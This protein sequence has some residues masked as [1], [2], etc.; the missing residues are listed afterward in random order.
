MS[1][2][3]L[4][5]RASVESTLGRAMNRLSAARGTSRYTGSRIE[6]RV[7]VFRE[8]RVGRCRKVRSVAACVSRCGVAVKGPGDTDRP[9]STFLHVE[10]VFWMREPLSA[11]V[12]C[13][14]VADRCSGAVSERG[15]GTANATDQ[16]D[17]AKSA[18]RSARCCARDGDPRTY[19][20]P[21]VP[22]GSCR[23]RK[24]LRMVVLT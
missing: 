6:G 9:R 14:R 24:R 4:P 1:T 7:I 5:T 17:N 19:P 8:G 12:R 10:A 18:A 13:G 23:N 3:L 21:Q 11:A 2:L 20:R 15:N 22:G 16:T